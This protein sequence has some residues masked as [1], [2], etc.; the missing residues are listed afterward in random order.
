MKE[1]LAADDIWI[2]V[3]DEFLDTAKLFTRHL[4]R[5]EYQRLKN[6]AK[7]E[8]ARRT[9]NLSRPSVNEDAASAD[10]TRMEKSRKRDQTQQAAVAGLA[11]TAHDISSD[12]DAP[13]MFE[14]HLGKLM[15]RPPPISKNL[16]SAAG[17]KSKSRAAAGY[18][19]ARLSPPHRTTKPSAVS[20]SADYNSMAGLAQ[21][22][23]AVKERLLSEDENDLDAPAPA[24][25]SRRPEANRDDRVPAAHSVSVKQK[26]SHNA[27]DI[28]KPS[29]RVSLGKSSIAQGSTQASTSTRGSKPTPK[30][31]STT[32]RS[33]Y[34]ERSVPKA[35]SVADED[36]W[37][38]K[39]STSLKTRELLNRRRAERAKKQ[40]EEEKQQNNKS[41]SLDEIPTFLF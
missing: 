27:S 34:T 6:L 21:E 40:K 5:A 15:R 2:M 41:Y 36:D 37:S 26:A 30:S 1:G 9:N 14:P 33:F 39:S 22:I 24:R 8:T 20:S 28:Q 17:I 18:K 23:G 12:D 29:E 4:H 7:L 19:K 25:F 3:E 10:I 32:R 35:S 13:W 11:A 31:D 16:A 38:M